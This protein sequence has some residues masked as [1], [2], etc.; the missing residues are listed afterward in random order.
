MLEHFG[1]YK[2]KFT[3]LELLGRAEQ[4]E[5]EV[6]SSEGTGVRFWDSFAMDEYREIIL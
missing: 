2:K 6:E 4:D 3:Y 5:D 1:L